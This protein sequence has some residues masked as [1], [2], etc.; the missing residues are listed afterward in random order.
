MNKWIR[1]NA[2]FAGKN[3]YLIKIKG[4][5]QAYVYGDREFAYMNL[6]SEAKKYL[7]NWNPSESEGVRGPEVTD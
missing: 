2:G 6:A 1:T 5:Y 4:G 7:D 3:G